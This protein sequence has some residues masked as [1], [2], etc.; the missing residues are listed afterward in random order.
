MQN[1]ENLEKEVA[2]K[3]EQREKK[4]RKR[5]HQSGK[6]VFALKKLI[7]VKKHK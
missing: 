1:H 5:M 4:K 7:T 3:Y 6:S 2:K